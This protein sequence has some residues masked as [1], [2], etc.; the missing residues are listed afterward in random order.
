MGDIKED[1]KIYQRSCES[2][3]NVQSSKFSNISRSMIYAI[4]ATNWVLLYVGENPKIENLNNWLFSS[5]ILSFIYIFID[6]IHYFVDTCRYVVL[7][8]RL[9]DS[10]MEISERVSIGRKGMKS[11]SRY[12]FYAILGKSAITFITSIVFLIGLICK[13]V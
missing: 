5:V 6:V 3:K 9:Y 7:S 4:I 12:S 10:N 1:L 13:I 2:S 8:R 11:I